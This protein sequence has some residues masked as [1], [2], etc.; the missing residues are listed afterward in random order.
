VC[1]KAATPVGP[2][3]QSTRVHPARY[4]LPI[5]ANPIT[6]NQ[7]P[8]THGKAHARLRHIATVGGGIGVLLIGIIT[9]GSLGGVASAAT[10]HVDATTSW[11]VYHGNPLGSGV[12]T[13][14]VSFSSATAA[15]SSPV[16]DGQVYGEPLEVSWSD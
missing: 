15:W 2:Q 16:L 14:G 11:T 10:P 8:R 9:A 5:D 6:S 7:R 3:I 1:G 13:S 4:G 12:D